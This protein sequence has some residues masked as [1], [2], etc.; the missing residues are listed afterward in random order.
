[1]GVVATYYLV[2]DKIIDKVIKEDF[3]LNQ[4][5]YKNELQE[6]TYNGTE[7]EKSGLLFGSGVKSWHA[8]YELLKL[9]DKSDEKIFR[10]TCDVENE[11]EETT[12]NCRLNYIYS[13]DVIKMWNEIKKISVAEIESQTKNKKII[14]A[15]TNIDGYRTENITHTKHI[16]LEFMELF[17]SLW[18]A[19]QKKRGILIEFG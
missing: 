17:K 19:V 8:L 2:D 9:M 11:I 3:D 13:S 18:S 12:L 1:M 6:H 4:Y 16:V 15:V 14:Q 10:L 7:F 5:F